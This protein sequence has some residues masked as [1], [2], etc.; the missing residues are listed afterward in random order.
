MSADNRKIR[1][2]LVVMAVASL[3]LT[4]YASF[5][6]LP[7]GIPGPRYDSLETWFSLGIVTVT[8][9]GLFRL[10]RDK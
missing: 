6:E 8:Y 1:I 10:T 4:L 5:F 3:G 2:V 7:F 9:V